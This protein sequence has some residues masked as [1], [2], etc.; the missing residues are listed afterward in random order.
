MASNYD[1]DFPPLE[2]SS[3]LEKNR[4][5][6][7]FIQSTEVLP[8]GSLKHPSQAEQVLNWQTHNARI[9]NRVLNSIDQKIDRVSHHV[10]QH[11]HSLQ[12]MDSVFRDFAIDLQSKIS[13]LDADFHRYINHG[14]FGPDFNDKEREIKRLREQLDQLNRDHSHPVPPPYVPKP[15]TQTLM[16]PSSPSYPSSSKPPDDS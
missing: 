12:R 10:S 16:F 4:F 7:P 5:S 9:Q 1:Q 11:E 15:Y 6:R 8:D 14:Y 13:K 3:N 2:P